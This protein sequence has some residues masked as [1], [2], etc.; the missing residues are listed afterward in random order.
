MA[1][2]QLSASVTNPYFSFPLFPQG[3]L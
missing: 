3:H 1:L 2:R